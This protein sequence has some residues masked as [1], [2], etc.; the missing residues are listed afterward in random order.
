ME[1]IV[2]TTPDLSRPNGPLR[3]A[4]GGY[5]DSELVD[6]DLAKFRQLIRNAAHSSPEEAYPPGGAGVRAVAGPVISIRRCNPVPSATR[7]ERKN[8]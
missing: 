5:L 8:S 7:K 6:L 3:T 2:V 4:N 1:R